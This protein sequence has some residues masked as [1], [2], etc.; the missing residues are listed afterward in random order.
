M[1][2]KKIKKKV[3]KECYIVFGFN[4]LGMM[5]FA[6]KTHG[7]ISSLYDKLKEKCRKKIIKKLEKVF[8]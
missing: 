5:M 6:C 2:K 8:K 4:K 1:A 7:D 3:K